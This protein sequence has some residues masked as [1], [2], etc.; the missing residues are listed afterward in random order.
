MAQE[1][2][3]LEFFLQIYIASMQI[4]QEVLAFLSYIYLIGHISSI[5]ALNFT[6]P[7]HFAFFKPCQRHSKNN[8]KN[9]RHS[10]PMKLET[11]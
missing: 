9:L 5:T 3:L 1:S 6:N 2:H 8:K 7:S 4:A 11:S 10:K